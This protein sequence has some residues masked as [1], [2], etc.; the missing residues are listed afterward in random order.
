MCL[1][2]Y[3]SD[4]VYLSNENTYKGERKRCWRRDVYSACESKPSCVCSR[5]KSISLSKILFVCISFVVWS[6]ILVVKL[7]NETFYLY[8]QAC[9]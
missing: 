3:V 6:R 5:Q 2:F 4:M 8:Y 1:L 9:H 7:R